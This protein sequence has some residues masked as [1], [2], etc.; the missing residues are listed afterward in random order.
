MDNNYIFIPFSKMNTNE[1]ITYI[2]NIDAIYAK[3]IIGERLYYQVQLIN[4]RDSLEITNLLINS[5][6][7][8][9]L[10]NIIDNDDLLKLKIND[11]SYLKQFI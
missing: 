2:N 5:Y 1:L 4:G 11:F 3:Q 7:N 10:F 8:N 9:E 6:N